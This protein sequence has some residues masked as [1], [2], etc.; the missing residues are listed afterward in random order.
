MKCQNWMIGMHL[1]ELLIICSNL[2]LQYCDI[3]ISRK[4]EPGR[5]EWRGCC[6]SKDSLTRQFLLFSLSLTGTQHCVTTQLQSTLFNFNEQTGL[7]VGQAFEGK[8]PC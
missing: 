5:G 4:R 6:G 7:F 8:K 1:L 3:E 2:L